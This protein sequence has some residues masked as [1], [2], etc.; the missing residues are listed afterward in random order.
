M[1]VQS[2]RTIDPLS[3]FEMCHEGIRAK[4]LSLYIH[5]AHHHPRPRQAE[6]PPRPACTLGMGSDQSLPENDYPMP[7]PGFTYN[8]YYVM[9]WKYRSVYTETYD[10]GQVR[11]ASYTHGFNTYYADAVIGPGSTSE[12]YLQLIARSSLTSLFLEWYD[13]WKNFVALPEVRSVLQ[14]RFRALEATNRARRE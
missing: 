2:R 12:I 13:E 14:N 11:S 10:N 8:G 9:R 7:I 5:W 1:T 4:V 3:R 6:H